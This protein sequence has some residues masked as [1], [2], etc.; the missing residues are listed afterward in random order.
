MTISNLP[1]LCSAMLTAAMLNKQFTWDRGAQF[2]PTLFYDRGD[3]NE[4]LIVLGITGDFDGSITQWGLI[5]TKIVG[6]EVAGFVADEVDLIAPALVVQAVSRDG[7][8][9]MLAGYK[10]DDGGQLTFE[11]IQA[12]DVDDGVAVRALRKAIGVVG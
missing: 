8:C 3:K 11:P 2:L 5:A 7:G 9:R 4:Q 6:A 12:G 10:V 1:N